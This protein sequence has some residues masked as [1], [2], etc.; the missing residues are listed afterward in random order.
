MPPDERASDFKGMG[1]AQGRNR[2]S[3][4]R[5]F[6][7]LLY[8]LSYLGPRSVSRQVRVAS[9]C[10][11]Y[12][13][14]NRACPV[15][16]PKFCTSASGTGRTPLREGAGARPSPGNPLRKLAYCWPT[17]TPVAV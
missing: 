3:D 2:T 9:K 7:P 8:Q 5:I 15:P 12:R 13:G 11:S 6:N 17:T 16:S 14:W 10:R 4:T 1:G